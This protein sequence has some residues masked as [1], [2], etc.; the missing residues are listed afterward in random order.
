MGAVKP[1]KTEPASPCY[2]RHAA[3]VQ[4][5]AA[6]GASMPLKRHSG[7]GCALLARLK[8]ITSG[9][10]THSSAFSVAISGIVAVSC[11]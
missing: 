7:A 4:Y 8:E 2:R 3:L 6:S 5:V 1:I 11:C 10:F 9:K